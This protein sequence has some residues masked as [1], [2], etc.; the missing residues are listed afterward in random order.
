MLMSNMNRHKEMLVATHSPTCSALGGK[1]SFKSGKHV[2][3][4]CALSAPDDEDIL[5]IF[6]YAFFKLPHIRPS[7]HFMVWEFAAFPLTNTIPTH[8]MCLQLKQSIF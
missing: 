8:Y 5:F 7:F 2:Y 1:V 6:L 4:R 3:T